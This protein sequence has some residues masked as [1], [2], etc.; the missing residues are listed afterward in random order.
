MISSSLKE[1]LWWLYQRELLEAVM[2]YLPIIFM[3]QSAHI[4]ILTLT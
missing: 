2:T 3:Q 1:V 4:E